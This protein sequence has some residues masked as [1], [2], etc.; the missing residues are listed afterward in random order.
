[1]KKKL[2]HIVLI[3][4]V[5]AFAAFAGWKILKSNS[6][7][8][9]KEQSEVKEGAEKKDRVD[10]SAKQRENANLGIEE[11][12]PAKIKTSLS[13]YGKVTAN[14]ESLAHV[15][16]RFPGVVKAVKK[17]L[18]DVVQQGEV[19]G[20]VES[21]ESLNVYDI[22]SDLKG[23]IIQRDMTL[24]EFVNNDKMVFTVADMSTVWV[25]LNIFRQDFG[26][27]RKGQ[28]VEVHTGDRHDTEGGQPIKTQIDYISPFGAEGT[29]TMLARATVPNAKGDLRPGLFVTAEI[30]TGENDAPVTVKLSALQTLG[31][32]TVVFVE[33]GNVFEAREV[34]LGVRDSERVDVVFGLKPGE[35]YVSANS[36]VVKAELGKGEAEH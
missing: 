27:L 1:M 34:K 10:L 13:V 11:A 22:T 3:T 16:P 29:Q 24:G 12:G 7:P 20:I 2:I 17:R 25:D 21:N 5:I 4:A 23:T 26:L 9:G 14:E 15:M 28:Q 30:I 32:K 6:Q 35:K 31:N 33:E 18:G 8:A 19:L 36:F